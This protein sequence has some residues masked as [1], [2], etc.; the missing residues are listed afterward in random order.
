VSRPAP[1]A[2]PSD[3]PSDESTLGGYIA[4]HARPPA[5]GAPDGNS[6]TVEMLTDATGDAAHP[7]GGYLLYV[8]WGATTPTIR[9]HVESGYLAVGESEGEVRAALGRIPLFD[10]KRTLDTL[11]RASGAEGLH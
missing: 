6:Y 1:G 11:V 8:C 7:V 2:E 9:G 10:V 5:F 3:A 4:V